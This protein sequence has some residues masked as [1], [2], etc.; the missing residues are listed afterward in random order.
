MLSNP[1]LYGAMRWRDEIIEKTHDGIITYEKFLKL[2][3]LI[4]SRQNQKKRNVKSIFIFQMKIKCPNCNNHLTSERSVY[5]RKTDKTQVENN[6]YRCQV[7]ALKGVPSPFRIP[8]KFV[9]RAME[10]YFENFIAVDASFEETDKK[11]PINRIQ[12]LQ[13]EIA[14]IEGQRMKYQKAWAM[15]LLTDEEF[16]K[17]MNETKQI[18]IE[19]NKEIMSLQ[20]EPIHKVDMETVKETSRHFKANWTELT[21]EEKREFVERFISHI[22][23]VRYGESRGKGFR[24]FVYEIKHIEFR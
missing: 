4:S 24:D 7:C 17:Q 1:A 12:T 3:A 15:D 14:K 16:T 23:V 9:I 19:I 6:A 20:T 10:E 8:E 18:I 13:K 21:Q 2:Q 22:E 5:Y 11:S